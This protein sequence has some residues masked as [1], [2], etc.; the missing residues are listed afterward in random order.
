V[1]TEPPAADIRDLPLT[2]AIA[3]RY[4]TY[5]LSTIVSRSLP[6][7][8]D[9]LKPVHRRLLYAMRQL[10]LDPGAGF[11]KCA[12]VVG[13]VIGKFHPHGDV[14]VYDALVRLAQ[15]FALRYPLIEGH[16]N[17]GNVDG[18][19]AA[20]M[21][22][23][24]ARLTSV[25]EAMLDGID[26]DTV[27]FRATY[28]N[29]D[30][31]PVVLPAAFPN[32]LANGASGIAVGMATS[33]PPHNAGEICRALK[34]LIARPDADP[35]ALLDIV[36]GPDFPTGGVLTEPREVLAAAYAG[37]R[38]S[39]RLRAR[40]HVE[41]DAGGRHRRI[42][43]T[44][45]PYQVQKARLIERL[46]ELLAGR[47]APTPAEVR[48]ESTETVRIVLRLTD[49]D[50]QPDRLMEHLFRHT[51]LEVRIGLNMNVLV[52]G[53]TPK[54]VGL[55]DLLR[56]FL[57]HR[58]TVVRRR[59]RYRLER[60]L[61][62]LEIVEGLLLALADLDTVIRIIREEDDP[63]AGL[64]AHFGISDRQAEAI[65]NMRL[66]QLRKLSE[67]ELRREREDLARRRKE[68]ERLLRDDAA[69]WATVDAELD[70]IATKFG[71][72]GPLAGRRTTIA[73]P[74]TAAA[75][76]IEP[77]AAGLP[78]TVV[79]SERGWLRVL[80][81]RSDDQGEIRYKE[82][83]HEGFVVDARSDD[84]LILF[85]SNGRAYT[86]PCDRLPSGRGFG[87]PLRLMIDLA[88]GYRPVV[89]LVHTPGRRLLVASNRGRGFAV[90]EQELF[91]HTRA[92]KAILGLDDGDRA[93]HCRAIADGDDLVATVAGNRR[94]LIFPLAEV[95]VLARGKGV[96]LQRCAGAELAD[97]K[98]FRRVEGLSWRTA[99]GLR[100]EK[101][102]DL[103][104]GRRG[105]TGRT[106]P[107][108]FPAG[109]RFS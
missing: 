101:Q 62:R 86:L 47:R 92:G 74:A 19:G 35:A 10:K 77:V 105:Q 69:T 1:S 58:F 68:L 39:L 56:I 70:A 46:A 65:L 49:R 109:N 37:G 94:L 48:D 3:E 57:D 14:A 98:T 23:T 79:C 27:D 36:Q 12:R 96:I 54:L 18:D 60:M 100:T 73:A 67:L 45:I 84:R 53:R 76:A 32:L 31:E 59:S 51:E 20:A 24:E 64:M 15:D 16:G 80:A 63:K 26:E 11:K 108:G 78:V 52:D 22:Y 89:L 44:E 103:W 88:E 6:D 55:R 61:E 28:D 87:E 106:A 83:D 43:I 90:D 2:E 41:A 21:R 102:L 5:A 107:K 40:W 7:A 71:D 50:A 13:D 81:G 91:G 66:R 34:L 97:L 75:A 30:S 9:G 17:F 93:S 85:C 38:G 42:V 82:G 4:L 99:R 25:A 95:P 104:T 8:R 33:I 29:E 72:G